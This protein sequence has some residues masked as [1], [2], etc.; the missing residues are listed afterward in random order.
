MPSPE[1]A[2]EVSGPTG[3]AQ[4]LFLCEH[5][6]KEIPAVYD[7]LGLS[8]EVRN[9]HAAW[10]PGALL[11][12]RT[13]AAKFASPLV[14]GLVSRLVYDCNRPPES[15]D[16]IPV[17]SEIYD[18]PGNA[19]LDAAARAARVEAVYRPFCAAVDGA[20]DAAGPKAIVTIHSFTP[21]WFGQH[22]EVEIGILHDADSRLAD[23]VL[24]Y[25]EGGGF[26]VRRNQPYGP[27]HG[28]THS[29]KL[30]ALSRGL[31]NVMIEVR[32]DLLAAEGG[33][34]RVS[35]FLAAVLRQALADCGI[36]AEGAE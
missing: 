33:Q 11:L 34:D 24:N 15:E 25:A 19:G 4:V 8:G 30:H 12:A 28:V 7:G 10:D 36:V 27:E 20:V 1:K 32:N 16:A 18:I 17:K 22:R 3:R 31:L 2:V 6:S 13:L 5:A 9:S 26:D 23:A 14:T 35:A 29:L 21:V